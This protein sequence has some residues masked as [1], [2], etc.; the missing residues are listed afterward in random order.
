M[1]LVVVTQWVRTGRFKSHLTKASPAGQECTSTCHPAMGVRSW[2]ER[3]GRPRDGAPKRVES[4]T[5]GEPQ[6][7]QRGKPTVS[8]HRKATVLGAIQ[9]SAQDTTGVCRAG[10]GFRGGTRERGR[11]T[12]LRVIT[13][14]LG[15]R[16]TKGPGVIWGFLPDH[17]PE[18]DTTNA[19]EAG[20]VS[21]SERRAKRPERGRGQS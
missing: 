14:G 13:P 2:R 15:D 16:A 11:A 1:K 7:I 12:C 8:T 9:A 3:G 6:G 21:G 17:E 10:H 20:E 19:R 18:R 4:W 5:A